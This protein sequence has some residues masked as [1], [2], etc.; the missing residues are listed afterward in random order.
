MG[1][2]VRATVKLV[3]YIT[4]EYPEG[5]THFGWEVS[6]LALHQLKRDLAFSSGIEQVYQYFDE[7]VV[8][9]FVLIPERLPSEKE[10]G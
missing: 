8:V 6:L 3:K 4:V 9:S 2:K 1:N 10:T 5:A 7:K